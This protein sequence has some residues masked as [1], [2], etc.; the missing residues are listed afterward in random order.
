MNAE[1]NGIILRLN[2]YRESDF[3]AVVLTE[4]FG[5]INCLARSARK[6]RH[7]FF[8]G[9]QLFD[10]GILSLSK[11]N[12]SFFNIETITD[13][14]AFN[15]LSSNPI[16][17][18]FA[19]LFSEILDT[20]IPE[21]DIEYNIFIAHFIKCLNL[22]SKAHDDLESIMIATW[23]LCKVSIFTGIDPRSTNNIFRTDD[24]NWITHLANDQFLKYEPLAATQ[25]A[26][27]NLVCF[28]ES[29]YDVKF[30]IRKQI[31]DYIMK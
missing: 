25:R 2:P 12:N 21:E 13:K 11:K 18:L 24:L 14:K 10:Y 16:H 30:K 22:L 29:T 26:F 23:F 31:Q 20:L 1:S 3:I 8:S 6:S 9:L 19:N 7:R 15:M 17:F 4:K 5:K 28:I 27:I